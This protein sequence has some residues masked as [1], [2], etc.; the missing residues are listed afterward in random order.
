VILEIAHGIVGRKDLPIPSWLF[1]WAATVVL[2][3]S[4]VGLAVLWPE[5]KLGKAGFRPLPRLSKVLG[6]RVVEIVCGAIGIFLLGLTVYS[7]FSGVQTATANFA[8]EFVYVTF[9]LGVVGLS[10]V[11]GNVYNAFNPWRAAGRAVAWIA[12][13]AARGPVPA[14]LAYPERLGNW[15]A[16]V[17]IFMF[18]VTELIV[19]S[20]DPRPSVLATL[21][22]VYSAVT[23]VAMTLFGVDEWC[24][25]GEAFSLYFGLFSKLSVWGRREGVLGL[26]PPLTGLANFKA[27]AGTVA[28]LAV[29]I[30]TVTF[31]GVQEAPLWTNIAP[32]L[33]KFFHSFG[34]SLQAATNT[35]TFLG[36]LVAVGLIAGFYRLGIRGARSVGGGFTSGQLANAFVSS[37]IPIALAYVSAHYLTLLLYQGQSIISFGLIPPH[38]DLGYIAS[39]PL[40]R[41]STDIFGTANNAIDYGVIGAKGAWYWQVGFVVAGHVAALTLAHDRALTMYSDVR[42]AVRSQ[43]WMLGV[44]VG[45][46]SL[47]LWLLAQSNA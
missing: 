30:G 40:G 23:F 22:L 34:L 24:K 16:A 42:Q 19:S 33:S 46:T 44:M 13:T 37:L 43:Y 7:G 14:P 2:V 27:Q 8:P 36:M 21:V 11:F 6:S 17:G 12:Q 41:E 20:S 35:A 25:R 18:A 28:L 4:F 3:V 29:M 1:G 38:V 39:N 26:R 5:P 45:F 47:A 10:V 15:P 32:H 31:D 9:W